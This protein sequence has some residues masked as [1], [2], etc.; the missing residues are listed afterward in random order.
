VSSFGKKYVDFSGI[1]SPARPTARRSPTL[2]RR[3]EERRRRLAALDERER[4]RRVLRVAETGAPPRSPI[5]S[6]R[7]PASTIWCSDRDVE[8]AELRRH[9]RRERQHARR[10]R[11]EPEALG[12]RDRDAECAVSLLRSCARASKRAS[13]VASPSG[14]HGSSSTVKC[15]ASAP[16]KALRHERQRREHAMGREDHEPASSIVVR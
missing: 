7:M 11:A 5:G 3:Q 15:S 2:G 6:C 1:V 8:R 13:S 16:R 12:A 9:R 14:D 10:R 4:A